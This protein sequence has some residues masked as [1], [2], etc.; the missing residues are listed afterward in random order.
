M[1]QNNR[2][3]TRGVSERIPLELQ[4]LMWNALNAIP[5]PK[6]YFQVFRLFVLNGIQCIEHE[7]EEPPF[8]RKYLLPMIE[9]PITEKVYIIDDSDHS[10]MLLA[11][12]Y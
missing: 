6:D 7:Q 11:E 1:F 8:K 5:E 4:L 3:L 9:N 2:Y 12:E 10:T